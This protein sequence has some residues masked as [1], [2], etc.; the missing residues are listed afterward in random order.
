MLRERQGARVD[1]WLAQ[2]EQQEVSELKNLARGLKKDY[3]AVKAGLTTF[4]TTLVKSDTWPFA[5]Y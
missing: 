2:I 1:T 4:A 5:R 3:A